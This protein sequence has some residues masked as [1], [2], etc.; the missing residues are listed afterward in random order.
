MTD[1]VSEG[2]KLIVADIVAQLQRMSANAPGLANETR[3]VALKLKEWCVVQSLLLTKDVAGDHATTDQVSEGAIEK[4]NDQ[5]IKQTWYFTFGFGQPHE[6]KY[7]II[8]DATYHE[9]RER[10]NQVFARR[11]AFQYSEA[12]W[13]ES[14]VS[15]AEQYGLTRVH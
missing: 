5:D 3:Y 6:G 13:N 9:A 8:E 11:W 2:A 15:Q 4:P 12:E 10:M 7:H 1:Q 14:G